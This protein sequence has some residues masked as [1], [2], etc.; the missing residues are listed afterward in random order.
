MA[1]ELYQDR[2]ASC[3]GDGGQGVAGAYEPALAGE[4]SVDQLAALIERTMPEGAAEECVGDDARQVAE[5]IYGKFYSLE[6]RRRAG[7][8]PPGRVELLRLTSMQHRQALADLVGRFAP[9]PPATAGE[10]TPGLLASYFQS[11]GMNKATERK[12]ARAD[13]RVDFDFGADSPVD[14]VT[15]DQFSIVW[16]GSL[17]IPAT[18]DYEFRVRTENGARLYFNR[19][20][21][22]ADG[23]MRDDSSNT[24]GD[25]LIDVWV[26]AGEMREKSARIFLLGGRMYPLRLE[27]FKYQDATASIRLEWKPPHGAWA[28]INGDFLTTRFAGRTFVPQTAFPADDRSLGYERGSTV[29]AEWLAAANA[30]AL[31]A[32]AEIVER[33]PRLAGLDRSAGDAPQRAGDFVARLASAAFRRPLAD[34][35]R[36]RLSKLA[37]SDP[38]GVEAGVRRA[39]LT[40]LMSPSFL[41]SSLPPA[42]ATATP[43]SVAERLALTLWDSLPDEQLLAAVQQGELQTPEQIAAQAQRMLADPRARHKVGEF[44]QQWLQL[45]E[46]DLAKD[47]GLYPEFDEAVAAD[48]RRSIELFV[49]HVVWSEASDY[50]ELLLADYLFLSPRLQALYAAS[51]A[52]EAGPPDHSGFR[53]VRFAS[54]ER[55]GV[56]THPYL[57]SALA[58]HNNTSPI[59]RGVFLTRNIV[60][61]Q[62]KPPPV[63]IAFPEG[64]FDPHLTMREKV[65]QLTS[66]EAC[67][68][69]HS[70]I[71]PLGFSLENFDAVGRWRTSE[72]ERPVDSRSTY[73]TA[74]G[75]TLDISNARDVANYAV[76]NKSAHRAFVRKLFQHLTKQDPTAYSD[77]LLEM[78]RSEFAAEGFHIQRLIVQIAVASSGVDLKTAAKPRTIR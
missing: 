23:I 77:N 54:G 20:E 74:D 75:A 41:Y 2:C 34:E 1:D 21:L 66:A 22:Y 30:A 67:M 35:Q 61:R 62:L 5:Y 6:A 48:L 45:D 40:T 49:D 70:F 9:A 16:R 56:L 14:G 38:S 58:Y 47:R 68:A 19:D 44:F 37:A 76:G 43:H 18:G 46:R 71:N 72:R 63:A 11:D 78:L 69:C 13:E 73:R 53:Q 59:H 29:S 32:A 33:L 17:Q 57:L 36:E 42:E 55:S 64:Q 4:L 39:V 27:F 25:P 10:P 52:D 50:R 28:P 26:G 12:L 8:T 15:A 3:H 31:E 65:T 7:L 51:A 24:V 60:G